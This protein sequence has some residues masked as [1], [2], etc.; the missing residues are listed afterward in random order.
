MADKIR[1]AAGEDIALPDGGIGI[2]VSIGVTMRRQG[3]SPD[4]VI[5]RADH[6]MY[7]AKRG[8]RNRIVMEHEDPPIA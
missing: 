1:A 2:S 4:T 3:E 8:G 5:S 6:A 7:E